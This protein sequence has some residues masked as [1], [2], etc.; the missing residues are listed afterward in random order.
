MWFTKPGQRTIL[1]AVMEW[2]LGR[3]DGQHLIVGTN[4][5]ALCVRVGQRTCLKDLVITQ[6]DACSNRHY[7]NRSAPQQ[8][9]QLLMD[10]LSVATHELQYT[11][12]QERL[13]AS[14]SA[15][16]DCDS[17]AECNL[18]RLVVEIVDIAVQ[19]QL[20]HWL[21]RKVLLGPHL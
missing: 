15:T 21:Q 6:T 8:P 12:S 5:V 7:Q 9:T 14:G 11:P 16:S 3:I 17:R 1:M 10:S 13:P 4:A 2:A 20:P 19:R 18:F